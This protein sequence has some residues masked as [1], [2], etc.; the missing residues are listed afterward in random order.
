MANARLVAGEPTIAPRVSPVP[1]RMPLP[2]ALHHGSIYENQS[3]AARRYFAVTADPAP[4]AE[5]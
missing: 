5:P 2:P 3:E 1:V 4:T